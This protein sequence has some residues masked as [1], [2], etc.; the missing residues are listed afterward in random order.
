MASAGL[1][2]AQALR[3]YIEAAID[4]EN[5]RKDAQARAAWQACLEIMAEVKMPAI[6][7]LNHDVPL[8]ASTLRCSDCDAALQW[9]WSAAHERF[10]IQPCSVCIAKSLVGR[11]NGLEAQLREHMEEGGQGNGLGTHQ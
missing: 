4:L 3:L 2:K 5:R 7:G 8:G 9:H 1:E 10:W 11:V 6:E